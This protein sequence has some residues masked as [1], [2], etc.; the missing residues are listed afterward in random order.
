[1][2]IRI[3]AMVVVLYASHNIHCLLM[4]HYMNYVKSRKVTQLLETCKH[5]QICRNQGVERRDK[6]ESGD[7][8]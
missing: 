6:F 2:H 4:L 3:M 5:M 7:L 8:Q 1:M